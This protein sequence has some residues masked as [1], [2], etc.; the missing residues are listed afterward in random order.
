MSASLGRKACMVTVS[1]K[2]ETQGSGKH[3]NSGARNQRQNGFIQNVLV[4][5]KSLE[6]ASNSN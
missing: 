5:N 6:I 3:V 2:E 1:S 4:Q